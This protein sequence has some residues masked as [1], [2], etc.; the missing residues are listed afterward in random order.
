MT[1][2]LVIEEKY[3]GLE[4]RLGQEPDSVL[5]DA[6][7]ITRARVYQLRKERDIPSLRGPSKPAD[8]DFVSSAFADL[9]A[10]WVERNPG[11]SM[12]DLAARL[13]V[14]APNRISDWA[15]GSRRPTLQAL[16]DMADAVACQVV[17]DPRGIQIRRRRGPTTNEAWHERG[18]EE[19]Y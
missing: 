8:P 12:K 1:K 3:P 16:V 14:S 18:A 17:L 5:A 2:K 15:N 10:R 4:A 6:Y 19:A 9:R 13:G 11:R 7:G